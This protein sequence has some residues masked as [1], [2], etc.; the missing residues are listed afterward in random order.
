M[1]PADRLE[2][3]ILNLLVGWS[4]PGG[5]TFGIPLLQSFLKPLLGDTDPREV[6]DALILLVDA[7]MIRIERYEGGIFVPYDRRLGREYFYGPD[8]RCCALP[9]ARRHQQ[10]LSRG[11]RYGIFISHISEERPLA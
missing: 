6:I 11:N 1:L 3:A 9:R 7:E 4:D 10:E 8:V 5:R 2:L